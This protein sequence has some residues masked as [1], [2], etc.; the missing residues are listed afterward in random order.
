MA[1]LS[2][3]EIARAARGE[4]VFGPRPPEGGAAHVVEG[5][6]I[7]S[8]T[9]RPGELFFAIVGPRH[10]G[11]DFVGAAVAGGA[12]AAVVSKGGPEAYPG[13][14]ALVRVRDTTAALQ[15]L[16]AHARRRRPLRV[17]GITGSAGKTTAKEMTAAVLAGRYRTHRTEGNLN[18]TYGL[19]LVLLRTPEEAEVAVLEMGM[20]YAGEIERLT[21]IADPDVGVILNVLAVHLEHFGGLDDIARA[22]GE[23][24]AS[25]RP[26]AIAVYNADDP[27]ARRLGRAFPGTR[28]AYGLAP[29]AD[30]AAAGVVVEGLGGIRFELRARGGR[31]PVRLQ[32]PGRHN[33][34][35]ALAAAA[36]GQ[37]LG[38]DLPAIRRG[39]EGVRPPGMR[40]V[41]HRLPRGIELLDDSYN[42]NPAAMECAIAL[43]GEVR[44][45]GRRVLVMGDMLELGVHAK[46]AH[47]RIGRRVAAAGIDLFVAAGPLCRAAYETARAGS[48]VEARHFADAEAAAPFVVS[49]LRAGDVVLVKGSRGARMERVVRA[50]LEAKGGAGPAAGAGGPDAAGGPGVTAGPNAAGG[51]APGPGGDA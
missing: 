20:S 10:D 29:K 34:H 26:D 21:A 44:P 8:R 7:D 39:L 30:V 36:V 27:R 43:L 23:L 28:L 47:A 5:Y 51:P 45:R 32:V 41:L 38:V 49:A 16:G 2:L 14:P 48:G 50:V 9:A 22:K 4:L 42:S 37:A 24:F 3:E 31:E 15:A 1:R 17:V 35:N 18:N 6:S 13:A 25:M 19:P 11:H 46:R 33:V 12:A 40:G